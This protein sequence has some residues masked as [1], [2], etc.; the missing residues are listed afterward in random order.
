MTSADNTASVRT[1]TGTAKW[2]D[3]VKGFG[4]IAAEG[5]DS[6]ILLHANILRAFGQNSIADGAQI[7]AQAQMTERGWKVIEVIS[8]NPPIDIPLSPGTGALSVN[9]LKALPLE[10]ARV[11]WFDPV[12]GFGFVTVFGQPGDVFIHIEVLRAAGR[13]DLQ[14]GEAVAVRIVEGA[15]GRTAA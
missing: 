13:Q 6:D 10:P 8:I 5:V 11:K 9:E 15:R 3:P 12:K 7:K 14:P 4:F 2:F 1:V